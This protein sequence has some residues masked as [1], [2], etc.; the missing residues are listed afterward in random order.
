[1]CNDGQ[2]ITLPFS[3]EVGKKGLPAL[4]K[5]V[6]QLE[7]TW[8]GVSSETLGR[9]ARAIDGLRSFTPEPGR[10]IKV[11]Y[12]DSISEVPR[13]QRPLKATLYVRMQG[14]QVPAG[15]YECG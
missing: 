8:Q 4:D 9:L 13:S 5:L 2:E 3:Y 1:M 10:E 11:S 7:K 15:S 12:G 14:E 6:T